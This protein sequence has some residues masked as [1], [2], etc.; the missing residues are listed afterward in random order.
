MF[1]TGTGSSLLP[2][3]SD[4]NGTLF[5]EIL[6]RLFEFEFKGGLAMISGYTYSFV[7]PI[8]KEFGSIFRVGRSG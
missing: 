8:E 6:L 7:V 4:V 2:A 5:E 3:F 1:L